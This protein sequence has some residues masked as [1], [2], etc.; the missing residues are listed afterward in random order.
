M[1]PVPTYIH[2]E[3][4]MTPL[5]AAVPLDAIADESAGSTLPIDRGADDQAGTSSPYAQLVVAEDKSATI[6]SGVLDLDEDEDGD[7]DAEINGLLSRLKEDSVDEPLPE[8]DVERAGTWIVSRPGQKERPFEKTGPV[9]VPIAVPREE[10][11]RR[12]VKPSPSRL[13]EVAPPPI[14][15]SAGRTRKGTMPQQVPVPG[16]PTL[17]RRPTPPPTQVNPLGKAP[18]GQ[19]STVRPAP[20]RTSPP[21]A[22]SASGT[23]IAPK[24]PTIPPDRPSTSLPVVA[25]AGTPPATKP[26]PPRPIST[27]VPPVGRPPPIPGRSQA[28]PPLPPRSAFQQPARPGGAGQ[29][30]LVPPVTTAPIRAQTVVSPT[31]GP[32]R[33]VPGTRP[34]GRQTPVTGLPVT[35]RRPPPASEG[36]V[37]ARPAVVIGA[38][39]TVIGGPGGEGTGG[40][41]HGREPTPPPIQP[42]SIFGHDL[43][44]EKSLDEVIMAYLSEDSTED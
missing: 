5:P 14:P 17:P 34:G 9:A 25:G 27:A 44:S 6:V 41:R 29:S 22:Q 16:A 15:A 37:V 10:V 4:D 20:S 23:P 40:R 32:V 21:L 30:R 8:G 31:G 24:P 2:D 42:E 28:V 39:P 13:P 18:S 35:G 38:P 33:A 3:S 12:I 1:E 26:P 11:A 19:Y 43:I 36:V 7:E